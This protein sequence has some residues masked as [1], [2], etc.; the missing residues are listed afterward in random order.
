MNLVLRSLALLSAVVLNLA[1]LNAQSLLWEQSAGPAGGTVR[2]LARTPDGTLF[3]MVERYGLHRS[4]DNGSS[5]ALVAGQFTSYG[6]FHVHATRAGTLLLIT[7]DSALH[8][9]TDKGKTWSIV[10]GDVGAA[11]APA[12]DSSGGI[13]CAAADLHRIYRSTDDGVTWTGIV[14]GS[15]DFISALAVGADGRLVAA[16]ETESFPSI[17]NVKVSTDLGVTWN[18]A[19]LGDEST[20][21]VLA[22]CATPDENLYAGTSEKLFRSTDGGATWSGTVIQADDGEP[23][24]SYAAFAVFNDGSIVVGSHRGLYRSTDAGD[25]YSALGALGVGSLP[26]GLVVIPGNKLIVGTYYAGIYSHE[27]DRFVYSS[28]GLPPLGG[29]AVA[30]AS[31]KTSRTYVIAANGRFYSSPDG[32]SV[33]TEPSVGG[34]FYPAI[35]VGPD[36]RIYAGNGM[37]WEKGIIYSTDRGESWDSGSG[38]DGEWVLALLVGRQGTI[39]AG[40]ERCTD[41]FH[42]SETDGLFRSI[43]SG[44]TW[45]TLGVGL[46]GTSPQSIVELGDGTLFIGSRYDYPVMRLLPGDTTWREA[47]TGLPSRSG[48][49]YTL[50]TLVA[51]S[52]ENLYAGTWQGLFRSSNRGASWERVQALPDSAIT[53]VAVGPLYPGEMIYAATSSGLIYASSDN[54]VTWEGPDGFPTTTTPITDLRALM[55]DPFGLLTALDGVN[56]LYRA[57]PGSSVPE[58][59]LSRRAGLVAHPNPAGMRTT[60]EF[61]TH[62]AGAVR[63]LLYSSLGRRVGVI[64]EGEMG[65]GKHRIDLDLSGYPAGGYRLVLEGE[66]GIEQV[67]VMIVR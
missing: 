56:G 6:S 11:V 28:K 52:R 60:V 42:F 39:Y 33:W 31:D 63:L 15:G 9:S 16:V 3:A 43:D 22:L 54:G 27:G 55:V 10:K 18:E 13:I 57:W 1:C 38:M 34:Y 37:Y 36:D 17:R 4:V 29:G 25:H 7:A 61:E 65:S 66:G 24:L 2:S 21:T 48:H 32:N 5:W 59:D 35:A 50:H 14:I 44:K 20:T 41:C 40:V 19:L 30:F 64:A 58:A 51:D 46:R 47:S 8:R 23:A 49:Q 67:G 26:S 12:S 53:G 45:S 62:T